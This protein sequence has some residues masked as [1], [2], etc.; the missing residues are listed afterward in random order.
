[1]HDGVYMAH[2]EEWATQSKVHACREKHMQKKE[3]TKGRIYL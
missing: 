2:G 1:M 3:H